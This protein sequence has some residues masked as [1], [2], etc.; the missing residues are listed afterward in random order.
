[1]VI[2]RGLEIGPHFFPQELRAEV[3]RNFVRD[4]ILP[5]Q[6]INGLCGSNRDQTRYLFHKKTEPGRG[7]LLN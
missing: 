7:S 4:E 5:W 1:M 2:E 6:P 3:T